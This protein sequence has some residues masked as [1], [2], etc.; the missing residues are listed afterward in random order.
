MKLTPLELQVL[1][2][3]A[4]KAKEAGYC[5]QTF[6]WLG[7]NL[8]G[9]ELLNKANKDELRARLDPKSREILGRGGKVLTQRGV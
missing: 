2:E 3:E 4:E 7:H 5:R 8:W 6:E 1:V 9:V